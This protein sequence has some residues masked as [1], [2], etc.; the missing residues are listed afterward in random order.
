MKFFKKVDI[1]IVSALILVS[2][3]TWVIYNGFFSDKPA[4]AE[5]YYGSELVKTVVLNKGT[6]TRFS[7]P[8]NRHVVFH[9]FKDGSICFQE[10]DCPDK[11]CIKTGRL[12]K[13]GQTAA[14]LP[15]RIIMKIVPS[16]ERNDNDVDMIAG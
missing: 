14:C 16:G 4:K 9:L 10:S 7:I 12:S 13:V 1:I 6:D 2:A 3:L 15:N 5:I 11:I 8:Q